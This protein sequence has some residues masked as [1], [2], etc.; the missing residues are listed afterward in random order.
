MEEE[1][2][3]SDLET[4]I[5]L[6][7]PF[8]WPKG[9]QGSPCPFSALTIFV[10]S[11]QVMDLLVGAGGEDLNEALLICA[12]ALRAETQPH[13]PWAGWGALRGALGSVPTPGRVPTPSLPRWHL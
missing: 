13:E 4:W 5:P 12:D 7:L 6:P 9:T 11:H 3:R 10:G 2:K 8:L 1:G